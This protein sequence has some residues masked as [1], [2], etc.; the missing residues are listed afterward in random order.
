[1]KLLLDE[2]VS[3]RLARLLASEFPGSAHVSEVGLRGATDNAI[4]E[5]CRTN[6]FTLASKDTDFRERSSVEGQPPK[7]IWLDVGN[8]GTTV[9]AELLHRNVA[10]IL[11][12]ET[13]Q[14]SSFLT[15]SLDIG[16]I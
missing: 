4:W 3:P 11:E 2:N 7:V 10:R 14:E 9:I 13:Q 6:D 5:F 12:F 8:A 1:M 15:L 16:W